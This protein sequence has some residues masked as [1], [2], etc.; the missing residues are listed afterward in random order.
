MSAIAQ[1]QTC[2]QYSHDAFINL[3]D[4]TDEAPAEYAD[5]LRKLAEKTHSL[6]ETMCRDLLS[7]RVLAESRA[8]QDDAGDAMEVAERPANFEMT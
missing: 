8:A 6:Y 7:R 4:A 3:S 5:C 2:L 1:L